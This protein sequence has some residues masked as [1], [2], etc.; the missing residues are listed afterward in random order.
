M[1]L[2]GRTRWSYAAASLGLASSLFLTAC[3]AGGG[4]A[5]ADESL[6]SMDPRTFTWGFV[7]GPDSVQA[8]SFKVFADEVAE[9]SNGKLIFEGTYSGSLIAGGEE[10]DGVM[11]GTADGTVLAVNQFPQDFPASVALVNLAYKPASTLP[12]GLLS[13]SA[14]VMQMH[15]DEDVLAQEAEDH[16][17][18]VL[19]AAQSSVSW[20]L[21]CTSPLDSLEDAEGLR[22]RVGGPPWVSQVEALGMTPVQVSMAET[23]EALQRGLVDCAIAPPPLIMDF[24]LWGAA[25]HYVPIS[26]S[27]YNGTLQVM[28]LDSWNNLPTDAQQVIKDA[29]QDW[30]MSENEE[31]VRAYERFANEAAEHDLEFHDPSSLDAVLDEFY[32]N[33]EQ[34]VVDSFPDAIGDPD[35]FVQAYEDA[36]AKWHQIAIDELGPEKDLS[37]LAT[38]DYDFDGWRDKTTELFTAMHG[39]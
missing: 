21:L 20:S 39:S 16:N 3:G 11:S 27:G 22:V 7:A 6:E 15:T 13:G 4:A 1:K 30:W 33:G 24:D 29:L 14:A 9:K 19:W 37:D 12:H 2:R 17:L 31:N 34:A 10:L 32:A 5:G 26:L 23:Y 28:N 35:Q 8:R 36:I 38:D 18:K 25:K